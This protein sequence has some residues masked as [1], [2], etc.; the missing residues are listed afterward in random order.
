M[1]HIPHHSPPP[2]D[3]SHPSHGMPENKPSQMA[4][5]ALFC[6]VGAWT[7]LPALA[8]IAAVICGHIER[9]KILQGEAPS[10]GLTVAT[11]GMILGYIQLGLVALGI[12]ALI[13]FFGLMALGIA[14]L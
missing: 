6:G 13:A 8:A 4:W 9:K 5:A 1:T 12:F 3:P 14:I 7:L 11:V 10:A 2:Y